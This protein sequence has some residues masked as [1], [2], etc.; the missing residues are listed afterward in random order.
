[1]C[2]KYVRNLTPY[3]GFNHDRFPAVCALS[4]F[5]QKAVAP[6]ISIYAAEL[7]V[8]SQVLSTVA[9]EACFGAR[10]C[11]VGQWSVSHTSQS[12]C[13]FPS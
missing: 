7:G 4:L 11:G 3:Q 13:K 1:M 10:V 6:A 8:V 12:C 2:V 5:Y 9:G